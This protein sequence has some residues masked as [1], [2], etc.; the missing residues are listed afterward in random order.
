MR[1]IKDIA[2]IVFEAIDRENNSIW[3][4]D[5]LYGH[6][7]TIQIDKRGSFGERLVYLSLSD[8]FQR[9]IEYNDGDQSDWD[10]KI[11]NKK[12]EIKTASLDVNNKFQNE[13]IKKDGDYFGLIFIGI[14]PNKIYIK[15]VKQTDINFDDLHNREEAKTGAG[16]K[17]D[18]KPEE[19][20]EIQTTEE[21]FQIFKSTF[22]LDNITGR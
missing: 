15:C 2:K 16:Y 22:G 17:W 7:R 8:Y 12:F 5:S 1:E 6:I 4:E 3:T 20:T 18:F 9:R 13:R 19:M 11:N 21:L 14:A 10:I